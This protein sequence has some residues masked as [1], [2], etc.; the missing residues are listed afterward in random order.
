VRTTPVLD[1]V[2]ID[3]DAL[4]LTMYFRSFVSAPLSLLKHL[5]TLLRL[6]EPWETA[7]AR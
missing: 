7:G 5:E 4:E 3:A 2:V 6:L 1:G